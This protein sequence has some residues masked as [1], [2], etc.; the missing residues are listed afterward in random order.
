MSRD[1]KK[2]HVNKNVMGSQ[3]NKNQEYEKQSRWSVTFLSPK[4][5]ES[6]PQSKLFWIDPSPKVLCTDLNYVSA[7][8][9]R[10]A[11]DGTKQVPET[12]LVR[13]HVP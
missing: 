6:L 1:Y 12:D 13:D 2:I 4:R 8:K 10:C 5:C 3:W 7:G 11:L 9:L